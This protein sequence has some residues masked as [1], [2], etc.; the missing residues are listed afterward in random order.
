MTINELLEKLMTG[1]TMG[2]A[3]VLLILLFSLIQ[4]SPIK[5]NP[6]DGIFGWIGSKVNGKMHDQIV[7]LKKE[8]SD[9]R[10][11]VR[12]L[13]INAHRQSIL[14]FAREC[15]SG[16]AHDAEEWNHILTVA[17]EYETYCKTH[18][19]SN[20]VVKADTAYIK[21]LYQQLCRNHEI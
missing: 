21:D 17:D 19:V 20:G 1:K 15:R 9:L 10:R 8:I 5:W 7:E 3:A 6:W 11:Q 4:I 14:T 16:I 18:E 13:W 2:W 12:D